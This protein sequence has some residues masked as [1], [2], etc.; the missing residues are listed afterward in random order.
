[1]NRS[2]GEMV[3]VLDSS[4]VDRRIELRSGQ[5][6]DYEIGMRCFSAKHAA[7]RRKSKNWLARDQN[8]VFEWTD[9]SARG[10][11]FQ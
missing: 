1:M 2:G 8:K 5:P 10:L 6:K 9:M 4:V 7:L 3:R 11:L